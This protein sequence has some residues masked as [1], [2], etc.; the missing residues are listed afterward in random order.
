MTTALPQ[1]ST[2]IISHH[3][4]YSYFASL[5]TTFTCK[6]LMPPHSW[7]RD[8]ECRRQWEYVQEHASALLLITV[9]HYFICQLSI[10]S[11][12][13][14]LFCVPL[15]GMSW[16]LDMWRWLPADVLQRATQPPSIDRHAPVKESE[17]G[18]HR[19]TTS[20]PIS[21]RPTGRKTAEGVMPETCPTQ[22]NPAPHTPPYFV[23]KIL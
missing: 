7:S 10:K 2:T 6:R 21:C 20:A 5:D 16:T 13:G 1:T 12:R 18:P 3:P 9:T 17:W 14:T 8:R 11:N 4:P 22:P 23:Y 15:A 19:W